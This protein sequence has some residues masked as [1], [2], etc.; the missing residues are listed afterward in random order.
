MLLLNHVRQNLQQHHSRYHTAFSEEMELYMRIS[1]SV[2]FY[3]YLIYICSVYIS[4]YIF[5]HT[6]IIKMCNFRGFRDM[7]K[8]THYV[9]I[10]IVLIRKNARV[11]SI[12]KLF[13]KVNVLPKT[14]IFYISLSTSNDLDKFH[15]LCRKIS[16]SMSSI[17]N[18]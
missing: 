1:I 7:A 15:L 16:H 14:I 11:M 17:Q 9:I 3:L 8:Q 6:H 5:I 13:A 12:Y 2:Y 18:Q 10:S 4:I